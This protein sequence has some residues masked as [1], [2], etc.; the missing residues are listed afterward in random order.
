MAVSSSMLLLSFFPFVVVCFR[1][2]VFSRFF[3]ASMFVAAFE[4]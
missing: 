2:N 1:L 4:P 3:I